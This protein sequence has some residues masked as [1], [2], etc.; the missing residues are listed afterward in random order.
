[1]TVGR[2]IDDGRERDDTTRARPVVGDDRLTPRFEEFL[3]DGTCYDV[4]VEPAGTG[5]TKRIGLFGYDCA[6]AAPASAN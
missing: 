6:A 4:G 5:T 1:M 3:T 2:R